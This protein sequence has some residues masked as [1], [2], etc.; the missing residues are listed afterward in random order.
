MLALGSLLAVTLSL[1]SAAVSL[2]HKYSIRT[3][4]HPPDNKVTPVLFSPPQFCV[5]LLNLLYQAIWSLWSPTPL[6]GIWPCA[7]SK[8]NNS[9]LSFSCSQLLVSHL[10]PRGLRQSLSAG[11]RL[12]RPARTK[13]LWTHVRKLESPASQMVVNM[14]TADILKKEILLYCSSELLLH[15]GFNFGHPE[16]TRMGLTLKFLPELSAGYFM[17]AYFLWAG[18]IFPSSSLPHSLCICF[19]EQ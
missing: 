7:C 4:P 17:P 13:C 14:E 5:A 12:R 15:T 9:P 18:C 11:Q 19:Q 1:T 16:G 10:W 2:R 8:E 6:I 3:T